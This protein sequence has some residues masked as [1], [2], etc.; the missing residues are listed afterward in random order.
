MAS[1]YPAPAWKAAV[2]KTDDEAANEAAEEK[3]VAAM[4]AEL[5]AAEARIEVAEARYKRANKQVAKELAK[6]LAESVAAKKEG[7]ADKGPTIAEVEAKN[8]SDGVGTGAATSKKGV[9]NTSAQTDKEVSS[10]RWLANKA[11]EKSV[12]DKAKKCRDKLRLSQRDKRMQFSESGDNVEEQAPA[13]VPSKPPAVEQKERSP[14]FESEEVKQGAKSLSERLACLKDVPNAAE[15]R[16]AASKVLTAGRENYFTGELSDVLIDLE[17][18]GLVEASLATE[19]KGLLKSEVAKTA[20]V[21]KEEW[22]AH[23]QK[24]SGVERKDEQPYKDSEVQYLKWVDRVGFISAEAELDAAQ[25]Q[26]EELLRHVDACLPAE[27]DEEATGST[28]KKP[29]PA[30]QKVDEDYAA[31]LEDQYDPERQSKGLKNTSALTQ[32]VAS[33]EK[34]E[35]AQG[36]DNKKFEKNIKA[37]EAGREGARDAKAGAADVPDDA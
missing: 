23:A 29:L 18:R 25:Q 33:K 26:L 34:W 15:K 10:Q 36:T 32:K 24:V 12:K 1:G 8:P 27:D 16:A 14:L 21:P 11:S 31:Q 2:Q 7:V 4:E 9:K 17:K 6:P 30:K 22:L 19:L 35:A 20:P 13:P 3:R 37:R 5:N 28:E